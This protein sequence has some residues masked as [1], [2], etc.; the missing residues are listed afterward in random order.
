MR[1]VTNVVRRAALFDMDRTLLETNTALLYTRYRRDRGEIGWGSM[2][3]VGYWLLQYSF[4]VIDAQKVALSALK[5]FSGK[6]ERL[7]VDNCEAWFQ[8]YVL[9]H[10]R[11]AARRTVDAHRRAGDHLAIV[12]GATPYATAPLARELGIEHI[13]TSELEVG[14]DGRLTG[15]PVDPLCY[16][17]GKVER[18]RVLAQKLGFELAEATFYSDSITDLPL[19]E[20]VGTPVAVSP[21][22]RLLRV[23]KQRGWRIEWWTAK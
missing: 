14:S 1:Y 6:E 9:R 10:V 2:L 8:S 4:G 21:D 19:L 23:A 17:A 15:R 3:Q 20:V 7:L 13:V 12:T 18:T 22:R 11:D 5:E 16:G